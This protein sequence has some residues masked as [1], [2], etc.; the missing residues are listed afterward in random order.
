MTATAVATA[1]AAIARSSKSFALASRLLP[2]P[3]R[4]RAAIVYAWCRRADDAVDAPGA[5]APAAVARLERELAQIYGGARCAD[6]ILDGFAAIV[7]DTRIPRRYPAELLAG[8]AMDARGQR[9]ETEA[10]LRLYC[11]RVAG[12]VG[13][14]MS[15]VMG[16]ADVRALAAAARLGLAMQLTNICRDVREDWAR[17]RLYLPS[18]LLAEVGGAWLVPCIGRPLP[19][20]AR[21]PL[22]RAIARLLA[23][24]RAEYRAGDRGLASLPPSCR[25][26]IA[27]ARRIYA[28]IGDEIER[29]E[30]DPFAPRAVVPGYRKLVLLASAATTSLTLPRPRR[31]AYR[32]DLPELGFEEIGAPAP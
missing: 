16:L 2:G 30:C 6:P 10:E 14:M 12:V 13:L 29:C 32:H 24:A 31:A 18:A 8:M 5:D 19:T 4:D 15:H 22:A 28:A 3:V 26:A 17:G 1:R 25:L 27:A 7:R 11:Y 21:W 23:R 20:T 9:Y